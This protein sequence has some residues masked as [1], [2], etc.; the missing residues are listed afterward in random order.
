MKYFCSLTR[1]VLC[2]SLAACASLPTDYERESSEAFKGH[3]STEFGARIAS[4]ST[5]HP[6]QSGF[7]LLRYGRQAFTGR[8]AVT[9]KAEQTLDVQ[10]YIWENDATG[11]ILSQR[12][13]EA[14]DRGIRVRV[15]LDDINLKGRDD[16]IASLDAHPNVEIRLFNPFAHRSAR[17]LD[18]LVDLGRVNHRMHNKLIIMDNAFA[19]VGGR[20]IGNHYFQVAE[21]ANFRDLDIVAAGPVVREIS[22]VFDYFFNGEWS[23]PIAALVDTPHTA[24]DLA[25]A[26]LALNELIASESYPYPL[27]QDVEEASEELNNILDTLIWAPGKIIWD[28]PKAI[29][30]TG[31]TSR[32]QEALHRRLETLEEELLIESAYF[33]L[34]DRGIETL[35]DLHKR[36]IRVRILTN[37]MQSNDV[38]AAH[39]GYAKRR[40]AMVEA[41]AELFELRPDAANIQQRVITGTSKAALHTKAIVFDRQDIFIGSYNLDPRSGDINTEAGLYVESVELAAQLVAYMDTGITPE[42]SY[43]VTLDENGDLL[44]LTGKDGDELKFHKD[45]GSTWWQRFQSGFIEMLPVEDQL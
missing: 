28:D 23:I 45:P 39:A 38:L 35:Q 20:N 41:G 9:A 8:V 44:W 1:W 16:H 17:A 19:I 36:G 34:R 25:K 21:D 7:A 13:L 33:V 12:L 43:R 18:F 37:S 26:R 24:D 22:T 27:D 14:A 15:L 29:Q 11:H 42:D 32:M 2:L 30:Q 4:A 3:E 5:E 31:S 40:K 6:G 10:Y